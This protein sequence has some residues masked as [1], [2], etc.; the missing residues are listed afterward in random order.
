[1]NTPIPVYNADGSLHAWA[2]EPQLAW[3]QSSGL[4]AR[5][6]R[7]RKGQVKRAILFLQPGEPKPARSVAVARYSFQELLANGP[8]WEL[9]HLGGSRG[10][11]NYAPPEARGDFLQVVA[12]CLAP[13]GSRDESAGGSLQVL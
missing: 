12:D 10:G 3:L 9:K 5:V 1:M 6:V 11:K 2:S 8:T 7:S 4:V 13:S